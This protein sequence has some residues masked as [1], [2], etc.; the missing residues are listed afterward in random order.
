MARQ[1]LDAM[2]SVDREDV[3]KIAT[4]KVQTLKNYIKKLKS[5]GVVMKKLLLTASKEQQRSIIARLIK[6][7]AFP[8]VNALRAV[9][10][11]RGLTHLL[12]K[13]YIPRTMLERAII[14]GNVW[15]VKWYYATQ[16]K[17][18]LNASKPD[19]TDMKYLSE[20]FATKEMTAAV[21]LGHPAP[22]NGD[23]S[24]NKSSNKSAKEPT[25][26]KRPQKRPQNW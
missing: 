19:R 14:A 6:T 15:A 16:W 9:K 18:L 24:S 25:V 2:W 20:E 1:I 3:K 21:L 5:S 7:G 22:K 23:K 8:G 17:T 11:N 4:S 12:R 10:V 13:R 26:Q